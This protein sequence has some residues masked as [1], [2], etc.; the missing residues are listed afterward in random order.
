MVEVN[1]DLEA[2]CRFAAANG[3]D[4]VELNM[5][6]A[7]HYA[8]ADPAAI[9]ES[10]ASEGLDLVVHLPYRLD[11]CSPWEHVREGACRELGAAVDAAV[12]MGAERGVFHART[13]ADTARWEAERLRDCVV[14]GVAAV[15]DAAAER[16]FEACAENLKGPTFDL[17]D[18]PALLARTDAPVC[19][20]TGHAHATGQGAE[21]QAE[22]LI[23]HGQRVGHLHLNDTRR[24][25]DDEHL[26]VGLGRIDFGAIA[27]AMVEAD[28]EGTVTHEVFEPGAGHDYAAHGKAAFDDL[29]DAA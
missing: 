23:D 14:E 9:E 29:L 6:G 25:D 15:H 27:S 12:G 17:G 11:P 13:D 22:F 21:R 16:G 3:F 28:W 8:D 24:D 26:P 18:F 7:A 4:F 19:L 2:A 20:D 10:V 5:E 1:H